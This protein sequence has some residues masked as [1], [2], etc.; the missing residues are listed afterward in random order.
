MGKKQNGRAAGRIR[1]QD[2]RFFS[3]LIWM[4]HDPRQ[5]KPLVVKDD[6]LPFLTSR[7]LG[8]CRIVGSIDASLKK[9]RK[10]IV[11]ENCL[12]K[13]K[14]KNMAYAKRTHSDSRA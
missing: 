7:R 4:L 1:T 8:C 12:N 9:E 14:A 6:R 3:R 10:N 5:S 13:R 11:E 2:T